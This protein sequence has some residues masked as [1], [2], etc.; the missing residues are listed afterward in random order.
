MTKQE[1]IDGYVEFLGRYSWDLIAT[2]TFR[3][4]PSVFKARRRF[5]EWISSV[6]EKV[7]T[8]S[9][10]WVRVTETGAYGDNVHFHLLLGGLRSKSLRW[11]LLW[12]QLAGF[13]DIAPFDPNRGG[14]RYMFKTIRPG[15]DFD[16]EL[17]LAP[18][19]SE[20]GRR[21]S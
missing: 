3:G 17:H 9:F 21:T 15:Q 18:L 7:G 1:L 16:L 19:P 14:I 8:R 12:Q 4:Y 11:I 2:L 6:E 5:D 10:R 20:I 13:A